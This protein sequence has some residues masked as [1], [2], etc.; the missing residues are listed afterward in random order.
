[1]TKNLCLRP[2]LAMFDT[3]RRKHFTVD[4]FKNLAYL[5]ED[6]TKKY[7]ATFHPE[8]LERIIEFKSKCTVDMTLFETI[9]TGVAFIGDLSSHEETHMHSDR[10]DAC[11]ILIQFG[12]TDVTGGD[13][14]FLTTKTMNLH[15]LLTNLYMVAT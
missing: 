4:W 14:N 13:T 7:L 5:A 11:S 9:F 15:A 12:N 3:E 8:L 1:M 2:N 6:K 10:V